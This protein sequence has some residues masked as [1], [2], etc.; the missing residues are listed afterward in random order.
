MKRTVK[1]NGIRHSHCMCIFLFE[2][3]GISNDIFIFS[4]SKETDIRSNPSIL[5]IIMFMVDKSN[6]ESKVGEVNIDVST[7]NPN[8]LTKTWYEIDSKVIYGKSK[9]KIS[10]EILLIT[11]SVCFNFILYKSILFLYLIHL[12]SNIQEKTKDQ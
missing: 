2:L 8:V 9:P 6:H 11:E 3:K 12:G 10:L 7:L 1:L 5:R 4:I